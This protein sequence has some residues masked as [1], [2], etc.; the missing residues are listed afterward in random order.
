MEGV[1]PVTYSE[2]PALG[3]VELPTVG[4]REDIVAELQELEARRYELR[5][6]LLEG[7]SVVE[8]R[9]VLSEQL[10]MTEFEATCYRTI[11]NGSP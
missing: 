11:L 10:N 6:K 1:T 5:E 9:E 3:G 2:L 7:L 8:A 4:S